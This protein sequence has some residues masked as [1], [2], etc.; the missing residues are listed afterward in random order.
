MTNQPVD[1]GTITDYLLGATSEA[2]TERL[3]E[4]S[5]TDDD[6]AARLHAVEN[7]LVDS[8]ISGELFGDTVARFN[9]YYLASP[10]R[11]EKV[12]FAQTFLAFGDKDAAAQAEKIQP[13]TP[14]RK[15]VVREPARFSLFALPRLRLQW[16]LAAFALVILLAGGYL[17]FQNVRLRDQMARTQTQRAELEHREQELQRE[18]AEQRSADAE[19]EKELARVREQ[20]AQLDQQLAARAEPVKPDREPR[21]LNVIAFNLSPQIRGIGQIPIVS[22]PGGTDQVALTLELEATGFP[23]YRAALKNPGTGQILWR[24]GKLK[25][26]VNTKAVRVSV[27]ARILNTQNYV[28]ELSGISTT[29]QGETVSSYPFRVVIQ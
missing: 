25:A 21:D 28:L 14:G 7:D 23:A 29:G 1:E 11:R 19:T 2:E 5:L 16:G 6:F 22:V 12:R 3:D 20:L 10:K 4:I 15:K 26:S 13:I 18:L 8:Y 9:S 27:P 17:M 24:S